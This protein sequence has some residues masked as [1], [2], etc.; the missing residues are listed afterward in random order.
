MLDANSFRS[1]GT[2]FEV[3]GIGIGDHSLEFRSR[4][5]FDSRQGIE[6]LYASSG[7]QSPVD[8]TNRLRYRDTNNDGQTT[9]RFSVVPDQTS[10][11]AF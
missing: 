5:C 10:N 6:L 11:R 4:R 9:R 1:F 3:V 2:T 7:S 8:L